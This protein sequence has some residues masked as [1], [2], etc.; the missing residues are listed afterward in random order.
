M[1]DWRPLIDSLPAVAE[2]GGFS[3]VVTRERLVDALSLQTKV[4]EA[5]LS[6]IE[7]L[8]VSLSLLDSELLP[9][10]QWRFVSFSASL[11]A[12]SVLQIL[13]DEQSRLLPRD[14]WLP[15]QPEPV[16]NA[17]RQLLHELEIRRVELHRQ[18]SA[19]PIR[20]VH[21]AWAF[22]LLDGQLLLHHREDQSRRDVANFVPI[23]GK[24]HWCDFPETL[25]QVT[26]LA[27]MQAPASTEVFEALP[28]TLMREV[29]EETGLL[30]GEHYQFSEWKRLKPYR[31][32]EGAG[33]R[34]GYTEYRIVIYQLQLNRSGFLKL[35]QH[36][37]NSSALVWFSPVEV[38]QGFRSD[39]KTAFVDALRAEWHDQTDEL[40]KALSMLPDSYKDESSK[41]A[42][43]QPVTLPLG[44]TPFLLGKTGQEKACYLSLTDEERLILLALGWHRR[45]MR[46]QPIEGLTAIPHGWVIAAHDEINRLLTNLTEKLT[47]QGVLLIECCNGNA[48]RLNTAHDTVYFDESLFALNIILDEARTGISITT[49]IQ[50]TQ[51]G[52][53]QNLAVFIALS[54]KLT[55]EIL[56][57]AQNTVYQVENPNLPGLLRR[58]IEKTTQALGLRKLMRQD[59]GVYALTI[60]DVHQ[61]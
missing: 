42:M 16:V 4:A 61:C 55:K 29:Q 20:Y 39:G 11:L 25:A 53:L 60:Q 21:V 22:I 52:A 28:Q 27:Y 48:Y 58:E 59:N 38:A 51:L 3:T 56:Q 18:Q 54:H 24:L 17:Q 23:G 34:H 40:A 43:T 9:S 14:F 35:V 1:L 30:H 26:A 33:S 46:W 44:D 10:G 32:V 45:G 37:Q 13:G 50:T 41:S 47:N 5:H 57:V 36:V 2:E 12:R 19:L 7:R 8:F 31:K 49:C 6:V 15:D